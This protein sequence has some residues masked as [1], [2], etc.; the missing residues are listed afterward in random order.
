MQYMRDMMDGRAALIELDN[1][2]H[3]EVKWTSVKEFLKQ[4]NV[5]KLI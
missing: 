2:R 4:Q 3:P 1:E 5:E